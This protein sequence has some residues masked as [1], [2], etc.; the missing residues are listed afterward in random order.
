MTDSGEQV[1]AQIR[2]EYG[3]RTILSFS[4]GKDAIAAYIAMRP[5]FDEIIP[6]YLFI[7]PGLEFVE[8]LL[9]Y[10]E[11]VMGRKIWR[12][13][14]PS[15]YQHLNELLFQTP[16]R[17]AVLEAANLPSFDYNDVVSMIAEAEG[18]DRPM[19]ATG[20]RAADSPMRRT[21]LAT[22]GAIS[23][24]TRRYFPIWDWPKQRLLQEITASGIKL[25]VDYLWF[26][27]SFDGLDYRFLAPLKE[28]APRDYAKV[29]EWYPMAP[30][31]LWRYEN[32]K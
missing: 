29:C 23:R 19:V 31:E 32:A 25:P 4:A 17:V 26:N 12:M 9:A 8:D 7:C 30:L 11:R 21:S 2:A 5:H 15:L 27:R 16:E 20:V 24:N 13:P 10:Y 28:H 1:I 6:Y 22:H 14:H 18:I 3:P